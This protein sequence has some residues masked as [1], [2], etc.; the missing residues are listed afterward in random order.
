MS[1][2]EF[3]EFALRMREAG[4]VKV[5]DGDREVIWPGPLM[6]SASA[7]SGFTRSRATPNPSANGHAETLTPE[8]ARLRA[9]RRELAGEDD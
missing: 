4:A 1:P 9:Y 3:S 5:R 8:E 6:P 2:A 7:Q